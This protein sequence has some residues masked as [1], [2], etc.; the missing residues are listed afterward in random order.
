[1]MPTHGAILLG[2]VARHLATVHITCNFCPR[3]G[4]ASVSR[5]MQEHGAPDMPVPDL[6]RM[7]SP[8]IA[9]ARMPIGR[10]AWTQRPLCLGADLP[11]AILASAPPRG[12]QRWV[13]SIFAS[14][15][16]LNSI[17]ICDWQDLRSL[18]R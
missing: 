10:P 5:L 15:S 11:A 13:L 17:L 14:G 9:R 18:S 8:T 1:M 7:R 3:H 2:E 6:L 4:K 12:L 16:R